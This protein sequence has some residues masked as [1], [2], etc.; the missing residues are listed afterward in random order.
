[1]AF[2]RLIQA[3][4]GSP[5]RG[6]NQLVIH[7]HELIEGLMVRL[8]EETDQHRV[9]L[10]RV[11]D[12]EAL[13]TGLRGV[14]GEGFLHIIVE[15]CQVEGQHACGLKSSLAVRRLTAWGVGIPGGALISWR[16][17]KRE[18][19]STCSKASRRAGSAVGK[20]AIIRVATS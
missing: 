7:L 20:R 19:A 11:E 9:P 1:M 12:T 10:G 8:H 5:I 2:D 17:D 4:L 18:S 3:P 13:D 14:P 15:P 16:G 6:R